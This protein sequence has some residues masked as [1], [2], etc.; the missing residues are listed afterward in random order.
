MGF[1]LL[2]TT[3]VTFLAAS[4]A[5]SPLYLV[6]QARWHFS[7]TTLTLVFASYAGALL[8]TLLTLGGLSDFLGRRPVLAAALVL[9]LVAMLGF[10]GARGLGWLLLA[11]AVQGVATGIAAGVLSAAL[12]DLAPPGRPSLAAAVNT[13]G[14]AAGLAVGALGSGALVQYAPAPRTLVFAAL[15]AVF[16]LLLLALLVVPE[17]V[18]PQPGALRSLRPRASV[19]P[20]ARSAFR[21]AAPVLVATWAVGGL[22]LSLGPSLAAQIFGVQNHLVGGLV[23]TAVAGVSAVGSVL[24][25]SAPPRPTMVH[26]AVVLI[27]GVTLVLASIAVTSTAVFFTGLIVSGWGFGTAFVGAFGSVASLARPHQRAELFAS[28]FAVSYLAFGGSAVLAGLAVPPFGLRPTAIVYGGV[29]IALS[30]FAAVAGRVKPGPDAPTPQPV[31]QDLMP[32]GASSK[33]S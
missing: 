25:R 10:L 16:A 19:P 17:S 21:V 23:V 6:Y 32:V 33:G 5:P 22:V 9:E 29:V 12:A 4:S 1:W 8:L 15:L 24:T 28:L 26:G 27:L 3:L 2:A 31:R 13:A 11:R 7:A 30:L 14:P 18:Q 20:I